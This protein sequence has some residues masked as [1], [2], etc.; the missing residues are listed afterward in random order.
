MRLYEFEA[1]E[2]LKA[3]GVSVPSGKVIE[4]KEAIAAPCV[5]KAQ[6]LSGDRLKQGAVVLCTSNADVTTGLNLLN[7]KVNNEEVTKLLVE[8]FIKFDK[9]F[10]ISFTF[11]TDSRSPVLLFSAEGGAGIEARNVQKVVIDGLA[12]LTREQ[13]QQVSQTCADI[14]LKLWDVFVKEDCKLLEVNPLVQ[15]KSGFVCLDAHI[16]LDDAAKGRHSWSYEERSILGR[17]LTQRELLVKAASDADHRGTVKYIELDG[18]IAVLSAGG[19]GSLTCMDALIEQGGRPANYSEFSGNPSDE[20]M[21]V[22][23]KQAM[24]K[25]IKGCWIVGAIANFTRVDTMVEGIV[26]ALKEIN[27]TFPIVVRRAGPFEK[28]GLAMLREQA[29]ENNWDVEVY[30]AEEP[31]TATAK[32]MVGRAY[33]NSN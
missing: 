32:R 10:F 11:D 20:K 28:E 22:L 23:A 13:A 7:M 5:I 33:G 12:G 18:D 26:R 19:G 3:H 29:K 2:V 14:L 21:Y 17:K 16:E 6:V 15:A 27:P 24:S 9:E 25:S 1:K 4:R 8:D 30:G 31:L